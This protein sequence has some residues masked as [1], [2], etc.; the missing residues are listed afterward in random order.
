MSILHLS[1]TFISKFYHDKIKQRLDDNA[2]L[3]MTNTDSLVY[4]IKT[5]N[6]YKVALQNQH[7]YNT[8]KYPTSQTVQL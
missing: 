6:A 1:K 5:E 3:P 4:Y 8:I 2:K 7:A